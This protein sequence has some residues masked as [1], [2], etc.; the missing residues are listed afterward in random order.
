WN[1]LL[2][3][4]LIPVTLYCSVCLKKFDFYSKLRRHQLTHSGQRP[5]TCSICN[6]GFRQ[7]AHLKRHLESHAKPRPNWV[8]VTNSLQEQ[9]HTEDYVAKKQTCDTTSL[10][11]Q[12]QLGLYDSRE[13]LQT[14]IGISD[15]SYSGI[16]QVS[17]ETMEK[18]PKQHQCATCLKCFNAPSKL[19]RH[20]LIHTSERPFGCQLCSKAFRQ[21]AHLK[22]HLT[23]HFTQRKNRAKFKPLNV[24]SGKAPQSR[25]HQLNSSVKISACSSMPLAGETGEKI[26]F[27]ETFVTKKSE[28]NCIR[29]E[30]LPKDSKVMHECPVCFKCFSAPSKLRRHCL[31]HT[32]QRPFQCSLC[33]RSF[34]QLSHL[35][36]HY[37][38][39]TAP[40]KKRTLPLQ[41]HKAGNQPHSSKTRLRRFVSSLNRK[42][43]SVN[44]QQKQVSLKENILSSK[45]A[46]LSCTIGCKTTDANDNVWESDVLKYSENKDC[47]TSRQGYWCTVCSKSFNAPSKLRR[48]LL[49]HTGQRPFKCLVC[50]KAFTQRS[51]LKV[52]RCRRQSKGAGK[53]TL[54]EVQ[55]L[56]KLDKH[57]PTPNVLE[58]TDD[59]VNSQQPTTCNNTVTDSTDSFIP[60][61]NILKSSSV[62]IEDNS[63]LTSL[64]N[65]NIPSESMTNSTFEGVTDTTNQTKECGHQC[66]ICLKIFDFPS[67]LSRHLLIHM[68][69]RP[70][71]CAV[72][73]K[74]FR[75]LSHLQSHEKSTFRE[76]GVLHKGYGRSCV[77]TCV[78]D[79]N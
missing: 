63:Q 60:S 59:P 13:D 38:V 2:L 79:L 23:T 67:K 44:H 9:N 6:K 21:L 14:D 46:S 50:F 51:H 62:Y 39:H 30:L 29:G 69:I 28:E 7:T 45:S 10:E 78:Q 55:L 31:I 5:F 37:S 16:A 57:S 76:Q 53:S 56:E 73:S 48:H 11:K 26:P 49:I 54:S 32:G 12:E 3:L 33:Y 58:I 17:L 22:I 66:T 34:R 36:A 75:Q 64:P 42:F 43:R 47:S 4:A 52:H 41:L 20:V 72:C 65:A 77:M 27:Q 68:D 24:S 15:S 25:G 1:S 70:F 61:N 71:T 19:R 18:T 40:R 35:K 74:S 8:L